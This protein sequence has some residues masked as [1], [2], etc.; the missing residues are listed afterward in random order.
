VKGH[1][2][3]QARQ[4]AKRN[5]TFDRQAR[6]GEFAIT[7]RSLGEYQFK[8]M[9][10]RHAESSYGHL[11]GLLLGRADDAQLS[12]GEGESLI[13]NVTNDGIGLNG[14]GKSKAER[15]AQKKADRAARRSAKEKG[16]KGN[17][18]PGDVPESGQDGDFQDK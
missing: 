4:I 7:Q 17:P 15:K 1:K 3:G 6:S 12:N 8:L 10:E 9:E 2:C 18:A 16:L 5:S 11:S 13:G 14:K